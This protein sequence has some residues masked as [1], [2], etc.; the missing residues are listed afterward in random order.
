MLGAEL[1]HSTKEEIQMRGK[2]IANQLHL[3][4]ANRVGCS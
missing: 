3:D 4:V 2:V 1:F